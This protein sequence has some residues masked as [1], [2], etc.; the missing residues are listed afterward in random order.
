MSS[1]ERPPSAGPAT[2]C[3][4]PVVRVGRP[5]VHDASGPGPDLYLTIFVHFAF[6]RWL[7]ST[8]SMKAIPVTPSSTVGKSAFGGWRPAT[9]AR[10]AR[11][12]SR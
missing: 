11:Y 6:E 1:G 4:V 9:S 7:A 3:T 8:V 10:M 2:G 12:A 5:R